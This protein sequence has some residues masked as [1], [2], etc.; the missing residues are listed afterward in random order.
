[1]TTRF[2]FRLL[3]G[4]AILL[5]IPAL[6]LP[7]ARAQGSSLGS[8]T[9]QGRLNDAS[10]PANGLFDFQFS[11]YSSGAPGPGQIGTPIITPRVPI[12]NGL[13][14]V[15]LNFPELNTFNGAD[16][17][18]Q[19]TV[20]PG[21]VPT[22]YT[23]L[24]PRQQ[25]TSAPYAIRAGSAASATTAQSVVGPV[26]ASQITGTIS[27]A[28]LPPINHGAPPLAPGGI[29]LSDDPTNAALAAQGFA[30]MPNA[31][32]TLA[33]EA[34]NRQAGPRVPKATRRRPPSP[35]ACVGRRR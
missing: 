11:L 22:N 7:N 24:N 31:E 18:L 2:H 14:T 26:P 15:T 34:W 23:L 8:F 28:N 21:G 30:R 33:T 17:W 20:K 4:A 9:Y 25:I 32:M 6:S 35:R 27:T 1:M 29:V 16:R 3:A 12:T 19:I 13:F 5:S 10:G